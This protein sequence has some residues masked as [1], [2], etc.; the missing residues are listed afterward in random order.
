MLTNLTPQKSSNFSQEAHYENWRW[1]KSC[2]RLKNWATKPQLIPMS[3]VIRVSRFIV[4]SFLFI[5]IHCNVFCNF[6]TFRFLSPIMLVK[7]PADLFVLGMV[8]LVSGVLYL[9]G[10]IKMWSQLVVQF[11]PY[12]LADSA[13]F[14]ILQQKRFIFNCFATKQCWGMLKMWGQPELIFGAT[15]ATGGYV[16]FLPVR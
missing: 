6:E 10:L 15:G 4:S 2:E 7:W 16:K 11:M 1:Q 3:S 12:F 9:A 13:Y 5:I 14:N 8:Y